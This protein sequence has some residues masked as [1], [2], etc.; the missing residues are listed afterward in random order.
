MTIERKLLSEDEG[1]L[2]DEGRPIPSTDFPNERPVTL[3]DIE[4]VL[5]RENAD[6]DP[7]VDSDGLEYS[8]V[9]YLGKPVMRNAPGR[10]KSSQ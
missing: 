10:R 1:V 2:G 3:S 9:D 8:G 5:G 6:R 4:R 7:P